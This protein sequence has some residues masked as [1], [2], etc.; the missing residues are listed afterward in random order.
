M[1]N[2]YE[3]YLQFLDSYLKT[4]FEA[5]K[6]Y[7]NCKAGCAY[8]CKLGEYPVSN[9][10][11]SYMMFG[12]SFLNKEIKDEISSNIMILKNEVKKPATFYRCPF[13]MENSCSIYKYRPM[14]CR[15]HGLL[16]FRY[17]NDDNCHFNIPGCVEEGLNYS[18]VYDP[19]TKKISSEKFSKL[20]TDLEPCAYNVGLKYLLKNEYT[21]KL[22][23]EFGDAK[24]LIEWL[25]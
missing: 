25:R 4:Y 24:I 15:S 13:L 6:P 11:F 5:Q 8:C 19:V 12:F 3:E 7:I 16:Q 22:N 2:K 14:I 20:D 23:L 9:L 21:E 17:D 1:F 18:N 10:E